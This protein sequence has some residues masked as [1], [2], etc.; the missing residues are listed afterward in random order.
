MALTRFIV[1]KQQSRIH[2][3]KYLAMHAHMGLWCENI[4]AVVYMAF[5]HTLM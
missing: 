5:M 1:L 4:Q 2:F 3:R